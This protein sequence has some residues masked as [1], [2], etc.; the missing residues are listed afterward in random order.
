MSRVIGL[1]VGS[2]TIGVAISDAVGLCAHPLQTLA[3]RG[4]QQD[5]VQIAKLAQQWETRRIVVGLPYAPD[6]TEG[7]RAA[8]VRV[9]GDALCAAGFSVEYTDEQ[10]STVEANEVL[11][12]ADLSRERRTQVLD[13]L[14]AAIILQRWLDQQGGTEKVVPL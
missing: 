3:R 5:V 6:G 8:R 7:H 2:K 14:A 12:Q 11:L 13:K 10:F 9:L 4:T 1:D